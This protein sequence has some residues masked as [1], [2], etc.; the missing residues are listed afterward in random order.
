LS[1]PWDFIEPSTLGDLDANETFAGVG[2]VLHE[3]GRIEVGLSSLYAIFQGCPRENAAIREYGARAVFFQRADA[4]ER[5]AHTYF[6][7]NPEQA[8]EAHFDSLIRR[9]RLFAARRNEVA[10]GVLRTRFAHIGGATTPPK[11]IYYCLFPAYYDYRRFGADGD[12]EY[13][14]TSENLSKLASNLAVFEDELDLF[15]DPMVP[16]GGWP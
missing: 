2:R 7:A 14:Y 4:I 8:M 12:P 10:H 13:R 11:A 3:W 9:A 15:S 1:D 6:V 16:P 5:V